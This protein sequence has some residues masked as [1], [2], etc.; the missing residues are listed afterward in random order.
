MSHPA[1]T[2]LLNPGDPAHGHQEQRMNQV[3]LELD[4]TDAGSIDRTPWLLA[5]PN[6]P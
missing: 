3:A 1:A 6:A 2:L 4:T 5:D